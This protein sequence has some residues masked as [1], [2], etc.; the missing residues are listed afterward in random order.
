MFEAEG[1][2]LADSSLFDVLPTKILAGDPRKVLETK[3]QV[4]IPRSLA[5]K[6]G[7]DVVGMKFWVPV[8]NREAGSGC[9][10]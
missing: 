8:R 10:A 5:E 7:G 4:M 1:F 3:S 2:T 6:I 9:L